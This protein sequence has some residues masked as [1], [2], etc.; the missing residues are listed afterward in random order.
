[1]WQ[2]QVEHSLQQQPNTLIYQFKTFLP[3]WQLIVFIFT[4]YKTKNAKPQR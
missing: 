2:V 3:A 1:M 4:Q